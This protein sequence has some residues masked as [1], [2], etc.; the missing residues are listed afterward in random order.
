[1]KLK[2][3]ARPAQPRRR[4]ESL[5]LSTVSSDR[6]TVARIKRNANAPAIVDDL[7]AISVMSIGIGGTLGLFC[8]PALG[9]AL[10]FRSFGKIEPLTSQL[11][12]LKPAYAAHA[13]G[14][15]VAFL[16]MGPELVGSR[17]HWD[18][19]PNQRSQDRPAAGPEV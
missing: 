3:H 16:R 17:V 12:I 2:R 8:P 10:T 15:P 18:L 7:V 4:H 11:F 9:F 5:A 19:P 6:C 14:K 1:M 13:V